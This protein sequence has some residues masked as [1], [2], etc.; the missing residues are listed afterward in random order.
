[1]KLI[2]T[3]AVRYAAASAIALLA[4][5]AILTLL[6]Q[7]FGIWYVAA[8]TLS[9]TAGMFV[10]YALSVRFVFKLHRLRDRRVEFAGFALL[11]IVGLGVNAAVI[12]VA[13]RFAGL[14]YLVAK[15]IAA[16]FTFA[17]NFLLRRQLLFVQ[18]PLA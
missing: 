12:Y 11:G 10:A 4:D 18:R 5:M 9:F 7:V 1:M 2:V 6:V 8:A 17:C 13:V 14:H 16:L 3:E 15:C